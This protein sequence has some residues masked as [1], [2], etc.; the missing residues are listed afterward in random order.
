M[1]L[2]RIFD[3]LWIIST[4]GRLYAFVFFWDFGVH[5][6]LHN[7]AHSYPCVHTLIH[8]HL[9]NIAFAVQILPGLWSEVARPST[10]CEAPTGTKGALHSHAARLSACCCWWCYCSGPKYS[11]ACCACCAWLEAGK[12]LSRWRYRPRDWEWKG[13]AKS[14]MPICIWSVDELKIKTTLFLQRCELWS[15]PDVV[16]TCTSRQ[17]PNITDC[18][19]ETGGIHRD[20]CLNM[21][22]HPCTIL[23]I[24]VTRPS[25]C[26]HQEPKAVSLRQYLR[27]IHQYGA[28]AGSIASWLS[29]LWACGSKW[30][31]SKTTIGYYCNI[32]ALR[33]ARGWKGLWVACSVED[34][35]SLLFRNV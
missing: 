6:E 35:T 34:T 18:C 13:E 1:D 15:C 31:N 4:R 19:P 24:F 3:D 12:S 22:K 2:P 21:P 8:F 26:I 5:S 33:P 32:H 29:L 16:S 25:N 23:N 28:Y 7:V 17:S 14:D 9:A 30:V 11:C 10:P 27:E 20:A